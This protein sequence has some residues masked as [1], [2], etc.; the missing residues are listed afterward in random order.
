MALRDTE[1]F[2]R[3]C[4][5]LFDPNLDVSAGSPFDTQV[6]QRLVR[7]L[8]NDPF[9]V[10]LTTFLSDRLGQAFPELAAKE[11]DVI[12][13]LLIK[14]A[15][16]LW[17]PVV[18]E[19]KRI[20]NVSFRDPAILT[21][22]EV[23]AL[24]ANFFVPRHL[25]QFA[26]GVARIFFNAPQNVSITPTN[27]FTSK[28]GLHFF[29]T[30]VQSIRTQE[31]ILNVSSDGLYYFD[32]N[33]IA[34]KA[35]SEF[36]IGPSE[37]GSIA[38]VPAAVRVQNLR[39]FSR[40][41]NEEGAVE[42]VGRL[43][44]S[45]S[46]RSL[47]TL[48]GVAA[49]MLNAFPEVSRLNVVGFNDPEMQRDVIRG[50]GL[51]GLAAAGVLGVPVPDGEGKLR[52]RRFAVSDSVDF[53][54]IM[55][56]D[57][58]TWILTVFQA[59]GSTPV[60]LDLTVRKIVSATE[61]DVEEQRFVYSPTP[62]L[63]TLRKK[64]LTLSSIPGGILYPDSQNGT[65]AIPDGEVHIG[66]AYDVH[67]R[68]PGFDE[69][70]LA[71]DNVTDDEPLFSGSRLEISAG[72]IVQLNDMV[73]GVTYA[74]DD[75]T[76]KTLETA[77]F[78]GYS[79]Q[80]MDG[81]DAG[82]YRILEVTQ[83]VGQSPEL[84]VSPS[85][86]N[87]GATLYRWRL[88]DAI[89]IDLVN[90]KE[91]RVEGE[92]LRTIQGVDI[93]DTVSGV[94]FNDYGVV[95]GDTLR[96]VD[97]PDAS[98]Y[99]LVAGPIA[100]SFDKLQLDRAVTQ[101]RSNLQYI[102]FRPNAGGGVQRPLVRITKVEI[103]DSS[104]QPIG[105]V[106]PY[107]KPIDAQTRAFQN[108]TR[109]VKHDVRDARLGLLSR[110]A[111]NGVFLGS[112]AGSTLTFNVNG[113]LHTYTILIN[114]IPADTFVSV[115]NTFMYASAGIWQFAVLVTED[116][117]G[118]RPAYSDIA[119]VGGSART[120]IFGNEEYRSVRDIRS[121][122]VDEVGWSA[123][124]P[125][126][127]TTSRLDVVQVVDGNNIG[128]YEAPFY[129][130]LNMALLF[131]FTDPS[132]ALVV[133]EMDGFPGFAPEVVRRVQVG[134]RSL[135][136]VRL[137]F[138]EPTAFEVDD[139]TRFA[140]TTAAGE[141]SFLPDPTLAY[142]RIPALPSAATPTDGS[143]TA[144]GMTFSAASQ[145]FVKSAIRIGD[146]LEIENH[147]IAG[148]VVLTNPVNSLV[149][150]TLI[151]SL[152]GGPDRTLTF[153]RD[154]SSLSAT[155]V[156]RLG[157][158]DQINA[159]AGE[160]ICQLTGSNTVEFETSR[161]LVIR[162]SGT[163]NAIILGDMSGTSP[164]QSF[165]SADRTN[166]SPHRG[167]YKIIGFPATDQLSVTPTFDATITPF[168]SPVT[169]QTFKV[170]RQGVQRI[171]ATSMADNLAEAGLYYFDVELI[172]LGTGDQWN[173]DRGLQMRVQ[174]YRSDGYYLTSG[175]ANTTFSPIEE[176][177]LVL[178]RSIL[179]NGVDDDPQNATQ[180]TGQN[181]QITYE[182]TP[183]VNDL[184]NFL[185]SDVERVVC[186]SPLSRHLIP[187][188]V[189]FDVTYFGGSRE[190]VVVPEVEQ[191]IRSLFPQDA[192]DSSDVQKILLNRGAI[193]VTNPIDL[194]ALVHYTDR[195]VYA[196]RSQNS[197]STGRLAAFIPDRVKVTRTI[198]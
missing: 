41:D 106:V 14:P 171:T 124:A 61:L 164:L 108:S 167:A 72:P 135:G 20:D 120:A 139:N 116:Y 191:Y 152:D 113:T 130:E 95:E 129:I 26:R 119:L 2:V 37:L 189:R 179:E 177:G 29:P 185:S 42:Y 193:T 39:R 74:E 103:L 114:D 38:N 71:L 133:S 66:G 146:N 187:H 141:L 24:G 166:A 63:W 126:I 56:G 143:S 36:N 159:A 53:F 9:T 23:D 186:A 88:F 5:V 117:V 132:T 104:N 69:S 158:I 77:A 52:T 105:S 28:G 134:A 50:G 54:A 172:S 165:S 173:I 184:Q 101:S 89:N 15:I 8:G 151:F 161:D 112:T 181:L 33:V 176:I 115:I 197:L 4:A 48:R 55:D 148:T 87:P 16:V 18:R 136:S 3:E 118:I 64:E 122:T 180:L 90:P 144:G 58:D 111:D 27:F 123:L 102:V 31:M 30:E 121:D 60:A 195:S 17:D 1:I 32:V 140:V 190:S 156:S 174:G 160:E 178:S 154:D 142:Q 73:L 169:R 6:T 70:T 82:V 93:V 168:A 170:T 83:T 91:T 175:D 21:K 84:T 155:Q 188:F 59:F 127:D 137:Y 149:N 94:N 109:G 78:H 34:E 44:Q 183:L 150:Q 81:V 25:G 51:G 43:E 182:R 153:I 96:I 110:K 85:P 98:D 145:D 196:A 35:G 11:T 163:A 75:E 45:L 46:E 67:V 80:I 86:T 194:I 100:P 62:R 40:G 107:A 192:L 47:V 65:V 22:D 68:G 57:A 128:Y 79:L 13:D 19:N 147:P 97:G 49:K 7:R 92:D 10:D 99:T 12:A 157:V 138:L 76:H 198:T 131:P 162:A 125:S